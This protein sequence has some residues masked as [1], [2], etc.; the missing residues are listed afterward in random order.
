MLSHSVTFRTFDL[1]TVAGNR[2][3]TLTLL[4]H[5]HGLFAKADAK[6]RLVNGKVP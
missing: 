5:H 6:Q 1:T 2:M 3:V 4:L